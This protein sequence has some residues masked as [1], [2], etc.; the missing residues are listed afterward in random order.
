MQEEDIVA[1]L[2]EVVEILLP[3]SLCLIGHHGRGGVPR[4]VVIEL[5]LDHE[6]LILDWSGGFF[7]LAPI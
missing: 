6:R 3:P 4:E 5:M 7:M 2:V 1:L